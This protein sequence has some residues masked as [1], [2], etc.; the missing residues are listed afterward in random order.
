MEM[1][2]ERELESIANIADV[3]ERGLE[4]EY[5]VGNIRGEK[6]ENY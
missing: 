4:D 2:E 1:L 5:G 3:H 6:G